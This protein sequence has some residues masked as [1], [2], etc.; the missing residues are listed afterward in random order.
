MVERDQSVMVEGLNELNWS[1]SEIEALALVE[2]IRQLHT[3]LA[4]QTFDV[5]TYHISLKKVSFHFNSAKK[6]FDN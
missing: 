1:I 2:G 3:F 5:Y 4:N 6:S